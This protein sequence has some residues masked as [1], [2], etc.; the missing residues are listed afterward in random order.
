MKFLLLLLSAVVISAQSNRDDSRFTITSINRGNGDSRFSGNGNDRTSDRFT[1]DR[2]PT[3]RA[4]PDFYRIEVDI[5]RF[6]NAKGILANG[7]ACDMTKTCD[8]IITAFLDVQNPMSPFPATSATKSWTP[9]LTK[10]KSNSFSIGKSLNR[11]VCGGAVNRVNARVLVMDHDTFT[12]SDEIGRFDCKFDI[13]PRDISFDGQSAQ[14]GPSTECVP[15]KQQGQIRLFARVRAF[16]IPA[17]Q[18]RAV[19]T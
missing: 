2:A 4:A 8:P 9:I 18:C 13:R 3:N 15:E 1:G 17:S 14:W 6:D 7:K 11:D 16:E 19:R 5:V 12:S 10:S